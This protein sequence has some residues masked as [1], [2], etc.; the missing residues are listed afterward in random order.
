MLL[1]DLHATGEG[2]G[3][4]LGLQPYRL[5]RAG[6][7]GGEQQ[8]LRRVA[9]LQVHLERQ[10]RVGLGAVERLGFALGGVEIGRVGFPR[11]TARIARRRDAG[12]VGPIGGLVRRSVDLDADFGRSSWRR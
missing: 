1:T 6:V 11:G 10:G 7:V 9:W 5:D 12:D 8:F 4:S 2:R 3:L